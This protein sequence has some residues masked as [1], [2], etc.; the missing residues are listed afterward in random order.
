MA[1]IFE[2]IGLG[3]F[4]VEGEPGEPDSARLVPI[5]AGDASREEAWRNVPT[6]LPA[7]PSVSRDR[8]CPVELGL[9]G[10]GVWINGL[11]A[12]QPVGV[13][14]RSLRALVVAYPGGLSSK[15]LNELAGAKDAPSA[16][17]HL[18]EAYHE[19]RRVLRFPAV[20]GG[21][22]GGMLLY[23]IIDPEAGRVTPAP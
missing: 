10:C 12:T 21:R 8:K 6:V 9:E 18:A 19:W 7:R 15:Q 14:Y 16:L 22:R 1:F 17:R 11:P 5:P 4:V 23:R 2:V 13:A 20:Q 3:H